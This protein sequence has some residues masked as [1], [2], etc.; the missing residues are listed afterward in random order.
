M[1]LIKFS[2]ISMGDHAL[3]TSLCQDRQRAKLIFFSL[4]VRFIQE[5]ARDRAYV[6]AQFPVIDLAIASYAPGSELA[7]FVLLNA[8]ID[9]ASSRCT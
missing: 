3:E 5:D 7:A 1:R 2:L 9:H 8:I 6:S 4:K